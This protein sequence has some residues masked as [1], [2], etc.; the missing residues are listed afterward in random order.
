MRTEVLPTSIYLET[1]VGRIEVALA[2]A[3]LMIGIAGAALI[4]IRLFGRDR[5]W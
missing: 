2:V 5:I 1:S 3:L 4:L